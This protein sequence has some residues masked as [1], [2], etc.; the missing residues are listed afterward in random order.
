MMSNGYNGIGEMSR[1]VA[2]SSGW[3]GNHQLVANEG[4]DGGR[5][6]GQWRVDNERQ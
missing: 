3:S 1:R 4:I 2:C 6:G 5:A